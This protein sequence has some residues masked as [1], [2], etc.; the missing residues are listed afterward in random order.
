MVRLSPFKI[1][2]QPF[3]AQN[4]VFRPLCSHCMPSA[5]RCVRLKGELRLLIITLLS[6]FSPLAWLRSFFK[7]PQCYSRSL[8]PPPIQYINS[9][10]VLSCAADGLHHVTR[11]SPQ[12]N[13]LPSYP[14]DMRRYGRLSLFA[15]LCHGTRRLLRCPSRFVRVFCALCP[16]S[17]S[18]PLA[19]FP[20]PAQSFS[21]HFSFVSWASAGIISIL[22][23]MQK[24][25]F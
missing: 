5:L 20:A 16:V 12:A 25:H 9:D 15:L 24:R 14:A 21:P 17:P 23:N 4:M 22:K 19:F 1:P 11:V 6:F 10:N 2:L 13:R 18:C 7:K 3:P 8:Q